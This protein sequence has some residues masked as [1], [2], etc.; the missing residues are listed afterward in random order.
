MNDYQPS[1]DCIEFSLDDEKAVFL[2]DCAKGV[3]AGSKITV[4]GV[5]E[6]GRA[7]LAARECLGGNDKAFGQWR[8]RRLPWLDRQA[9][10]RFM[11]VTDRFSTATLCC[12][13][14]LLPTVLYELAAPSTPDSVISEVLARTESGERVRVAEVKRLVK[15]AKQRA[16]AA[17]TNVFHFPQVSEVS[18]P[19]P[20]VS[21]DAQPASSRVVFPDLA[22]EWVHHY[23]AVNQ[24]LRSVYR[25]Y[26]QGSDLGLSASVF[27]ASM[28]T[29]S[30]QDLSHIHNLA[31]FLV[32]VISELG[33]VQ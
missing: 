7:L 26:V 28:P 18:T 12:S 33:R 32:R 23:G 22:R 11:Q 24:A 19:V 4:E 1:F 6:I 10:L 27:V 3:E 9:A 2:E 14:N 21:V 13:R 16:K 30:R 29:S 8:E 20:L 15:E 17:D 5:F 31:D 25:E